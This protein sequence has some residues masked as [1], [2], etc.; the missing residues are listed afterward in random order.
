MDS[1]AS[2]A[3]PGCTAVSQA[4]TYTRVCA[5]VL[6]SS[7]KVYLVVE[8]HDYCCS[9]AM[10]P[11]SRTNSV[12]FAAS[13]Q[14][15]FLSSRQNLSVCSIRAYCCSVQT[16]MLLAS[17]RIYENTADTGTIAASRPFQ[18]AAYA[19]TGSS[20]EQQS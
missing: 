17:R 9:T 12:S 13:R 8:Q 1:G 3:T 18:Y 5:Q 16:D 20:R 7:G 2:G 6:T 10:E 19:P 14:T 11:D 15:H 4:S